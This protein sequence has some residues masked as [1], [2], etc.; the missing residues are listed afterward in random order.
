MS[1]SYRDRQHRW[2]PSRAFSA[3]TTSEG[4]N[5]CVLPSSTSG[6]QSPLVVEVVDLTKL[7]RDWHQASN[8]AQT[9]ERSRRQTCG[10]KLPGEIS[11]RR[12]AFHPKMFPYAVIW[13]LY[14]IIGI[15]VIGGSKMCSETNTQRCVPR[16]RLRRQLIAGCRAVCCFILV[17]KF[18]EIVILQL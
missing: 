13:L 5:A 16:A 17:P 12:P 4:S 7:C 9:G 2:L 15:G 8:K 18:C 14:S 1:V 6:R 3:T 10:R 11:P